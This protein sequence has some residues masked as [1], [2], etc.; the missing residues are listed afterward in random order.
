MEQ[1]DL[2]DLDIDELSPLPPA[3][4]F[5]NDRSTSL[6][7]IPSLRLNATPRT[8]PTHP[9]DSTAVASPALSAATSPF[10]LEASP[11]SSPR[12]HDDPKQ[13]FQTHSQLPSLRRPDASFEQK[14]TASQ[15][16]H[17]HEA[18]HDSQG[19]RQPL[20]PLSIPAQTPSA[21]YV[22]VSAILSRS[23][24]YYA[25]ET[26][27]QWDI[28]RSPHGL[29][30]DA[31]SSYDTNARPSSS[32]EPFS[33]LRR[34]KSQRKRPSNGSAIEALGA[35]LLRKDSSGR[36]ANL[37]FARSE[38]DDAKAGTSQKA[39][40]QK[41]KKGLGS[42]HGVQAWTSALGSISRN[43]LRLQLPQ[44]EPSQ[45][46]NSKH[47]ATIAE[48]RAHM[49]KKVLTRQGAVVEDTRNGFSKVRSRRGGLSFE[50]GNAGRKQT[51]ST[52]LQLDNY[53]PEGTAK[54]RGHANGSRPD[55]EDAFGSYEE[56][57]LH[58]DTLAGRSANGNEWSRLPET[59]VLKAGRR[60][61]IKQQ[62]KSEFGIGSAYHD[63]A[64]PEAPPSP[65]AM[66]GAWHGG[67]S[68]RSKPG[69]GYD[70]GA[71]LLPPPLLDDNGSDA[72]SFEGLLG[73]RRMREREKARKQA[74]K[75]AARNR[76]AH[77]VGPLTALTNFVKA[78]HAAETFAKRSQIGGRSGRAP[79]LLRSFTEPPK[80]SR[81][82][83]SSTES[84]SR[85][86]VAASPVIASSDAPRDVTADT[87][88][89]TL[90]ALRSS[91]ASAAVT[92][93]TTD[94]DA[95]T[96]PA[97]ASAS[98]FMS[99]SLRRAV[100]SRRG[101]RNN[102]ID[103]SGR[104][105]NTVFEFEPLD[106]SQIPDDELASPDL[107]PISSPLLRPSSTG[108]GKTSAFRDFPAAP[109]LLPVQLSVPPSPFTPL[110]VDLRESRNSVGTTSANG[111]YLSARNV[112]SSPRTPQL[113]PTMLSLPPSPW[114]PYQN[115]AAAHAQ[116][117]IHLHL[118]TSTSSLR[119]APGTPRLVPTHIEILPSPFPTSLSSRRGSLSYDSPHSLRAGALT[120]S[121]LTAPA[122]DF[123]SFAALRGSQAVDLESRQ[124][125][126][127]KVAAA[128]DDKGEDNT[129]DALKRDPLRL[130]PSS[131][132][133][134]TQSIFISDASD[135]SVREQNGPSHPHAA[136]R[137]TF[138]DDQLSRRAR[139]KSFESIRR[140]PS[141]DQGAIH[142]DSAGRPRSFVLWF[143]IGDLGLRG[144]ASSLADSGKQLDP[145]HGGV[146]ALFVHTFFFLVFVAAHVVDL[147]Y[148]M[149]D[150]ASLL[151]W[152][153][154]WM[155]FNLTGRTVLAQCIVEAYSFIQ[156]EWA[157]VAI[158]DHEEKGSKKVFHQRGHRKPKGLSRWQVL[159]GLVE[160]YCLHSV[161]RERY[162]EEGAGLKE[163]EGW[164]KA[165]KQENKGQ[166]Q[167]RKTRGSDRMDIGAH[168]A[169][170]RAALGADKEILERRHLS[171]VKQEIRNA[172]LATQE[173]NSDIR[174]QLRLEQL[175]D[176]E[177]DNGDN[178]NDND[179]GG[180]DGAE[181][182][183]SSDDE[184]IVTN[185]GDDILEFAKTPRIDAARPGQ[186]S[187]GYFGRAY[188]FVTSPQVGASESGPAGPGLTTFKETNRDLVRTIKWCGRLAISAY[189]LHVH[190]VDLPPTFT[191]SGDR[192]SRQTFAYLSRLNAE[193]VLHADIQTLDADADYSPTFYIVR[194]YVRKVVC[195]A[196]RGTQ[197]FSDIIVDLELQTEEI[198][199]PQVQPTPGEEFRCHAGIWRAAKALV[200][201]QSKLFAT[202][203][204]ALEENEGFGIM[205]CG[206]SLGGAIASAAA[207]L[208]AE[209]FIPDG[210]EPDAGTWV[211]N[212][213]SGLPARRL[214]RAVSFASPVTMTA[215][216]AS[217]AA[218]GSVPLVTTVVLGSDVIPRVGHG[219][220]RELRRVLGALSRVRRR[221]A[222]AS[223]EGRE[224]ARVHILRS[225][226]D[227]RSIKLAEDADDVM[228]H[229]KERIEHQL[230]SLRREVES[231]LYAAIKAR[232]DAESSS[233]ARIPPSPW[234]GPQ[235]RDQAP[236]HALSAR[237]QGL[238]A[239]TLRSE[240]AQGG[241]LIPP[242]RCIWINDRR[243]YHVESPLAFFSLPELRSDMFAAH[244]P[245]AYEEA[246][247][248]LRT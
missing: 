170:S 37:S 28:L 245:A 134:A 232:L 216:L 188:D 181:D 15:A 117:M 227:W 141:A 111:D 98:P 25:P 192:F 129:Q 128:E 74:E 56:P 234:V 159:R 70:E 50:V 200:S 160:L 201:P 174:P 97:V 120:R 133:L 24:M 26:S 173:S 135:I 54:Q 71:L 127:L 118:N 38:I 248:E 178:D 156:A 152:F 162:L 77:K 83:S 10:R 215:D 143:L 31:Q 167:K 65:V 19:S 153:L 87:A 142:V 67:S 75:L 163:L 57:G 35:L 116:P 165:S 219:Q 171:D 100:L 18:E 109:R 40:M 166:S 138:D 124:A 43:G 61:R 7:R 139:R 42:K 228:L 126:E 150:T 209:Y 158:E 177:D 154:R 41:E 203:R 137:T 131:M 59:I 204:Q 176:S 101:S 45:P 16:S 3:H 226:W 231:D 84:L 186:A 32:Y 194:D 17:Q 94:A 230:W 12:G 102:S 110:A 46:S 1:S 148:S 29:P 22:T 196:V 190:I 202:L 180:D 90:P 11:P 244:F 9:A 80:T 21:R 58:L 73:V 44:L 147:A 69:D 182:D 242:G 47:G 72:S 149:Y 114:T 93:V 104:M 175:N 85:I 105:L 76:P 220:V 207:L 79:S 210:A 136:T 217:R 164:R 240:A 191:P 243:I 214:I 233:A 236:L 229:R 189:G 197:S 5:S 241:P 88:D 27:E 183:D 140:R 14:G 89:T 108:S 121:P 145:D 193:D 212:M 51:Q 30:T 123:A 34:R 119:L 66:P 60:P 113:V 4:G 161:T 179:N 237:R 81:A 205:F 222:M 63:Q 151:L 20:E 107:P 168:R 82:R 221:H 13:H 169:A 144:S 6:E 206:H 198:E 195:V 146:A 112:H 223:T 99:P 96:S 157:T 235:Q 68:W 39:D 238:D 218:L 208:L 172:N 247:L 62:S 8:A 92:P 103:A 132:L 122:T 86:H 95:R 187:T 53:R 78:A 184:M 48:R 49:W 52:L 2:L 55:H 125:A 23:E 130:T 246:I 213:S 225:F 36:V 199:L 91:L 185:R 155:L 106:P 224:D 211:T 239:A 33:S 64:L 115:P